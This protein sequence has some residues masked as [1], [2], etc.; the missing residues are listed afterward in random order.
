MYFN[1]ARLGLFCTFY[2]LRFSMKNILELFFPSLNLYDMI[3]HGCPVVCHIG[4]AVIYITK[5]LLGV[6]IYWLCLLSVVFG[7][8]QLL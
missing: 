6:I 2:N 4:N 1:I 5:A 8:S 3:F 7:Q